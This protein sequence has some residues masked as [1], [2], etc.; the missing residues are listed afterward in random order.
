VYPIIFRLPEW[1]PLLG[2]EP[3]TSFGMFMF[4]AFLAGGTLLRAEMERVDLP[5]DKAWDMLFMAVLGGVLGARIYYIF[6]NYPQL[7]VDPK[8]LIFSRG[9]MVWYGGFIG[10]VVM[11][12]WEVHRSKLPRGRMADLV[13]A[14]LAVGYAVGRMGCFLVGDDYGRPTAG[15]WG[16]KFPQGTPATRVDL[17]ESHFGIT[18]DPAIVEQFGQVVPVHPTQLYEIAMS[19][20]IFAVIW[21]FR[22]HKHAAGW[23][24]WVWLGLAGV[25]RF[26]VEFVRVKD[27]RFLG[28]LT[29]A[30]FISILLIGLAIWGVNRTRKAEP[31]AA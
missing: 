29:I 23:L 9:G 7:A 17:L 28:P 3:I 15:W 22:A 25:E 20:A 12:L 11:C 8:G 5:P 21:R 4:F 19:L 2:G 30:Q 27:D 18:V 1:F 24:W 26:L 10:G 31:A 16:I 14:P 13:T 6:L